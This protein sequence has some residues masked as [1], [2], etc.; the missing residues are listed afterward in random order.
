MHVDLNPEFEKQL[1]ILRREFA[2]C[3]NINQFLLAH[4]AVSLLFTRKLQ[5]QLEKI[6]ELT[7]KQV[8]EININASPEAMSLLKALSEPK[9][10][11]LDKKVM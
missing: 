3:D 8:R 1:D 11:D 6:P 5:Q 7:N 2:N 9:T 10:L 4:Q